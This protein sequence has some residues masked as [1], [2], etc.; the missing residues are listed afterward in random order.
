MCKT[1]RGEESGCK[2]KKERGRI[3]KER[4]CH[5][6]ANRGTAEAKVI[7]CQM[8]AVKTNM[9]PSHGTKDSRE[10]YCRENA[11]ICNGVLHPGL[12]SLSIHHT[13]FIVLADGLV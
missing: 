4:S 8:A 1:E 2:R 5:F 9:T 10:R 7:Y 3:Q 11:H 6:A 13:L 12:M